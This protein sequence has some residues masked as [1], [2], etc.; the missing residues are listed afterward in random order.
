QAREPAGIYGHSLHA[1]S[2]D[3][4]LWGQGQ[5]II[6]YG[7]SQ[8]PKELPPSFEFS[9]RVIFAANVIPKNDAFK[10]V[11]SRCDQFELS[12]SNEEVRS[13]EHTSELQSRENLVCRLL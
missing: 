11:L 7:S 6:T 13:E 10:A 8:L 9:S 2:S 1:A 3:L 12:A 5:R 4:A